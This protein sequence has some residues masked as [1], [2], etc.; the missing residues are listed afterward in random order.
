MNT[1]QSETLIERI[2]TMEKEAKGKGHEMTFFTVTSPY[3]TDT[4]VKH[5]V[6][7]FN[8]AFSQIRAHLKRRDIDISGIRIIE[9]RPNGKPKFFILLF[10]DPKHAISIKKRSFH[11]LEK[12]KGFHITHKTKT[13]EPQQRIP[14][15]VERAN[16]WA[17]LHQIRIIT[18]FGQP[19]IPS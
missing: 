7:R 11:F 2:K 1:Q 9:P 15:Y 12:N 3:K 8:I 16:Y 19:L 4:S 18:F 10:S 17:K 14:D 6:K 5:T 13:N